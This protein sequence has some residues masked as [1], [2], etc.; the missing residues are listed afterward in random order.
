MVGL[1][2]IEKKIRLSLNVI[3]TQ[4]AVRRGPWKF[5]CVVVSTEFYAEISIHWFGND[6]ICGAESRECLT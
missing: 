3:V 4:F 5:Q 1:G 6:G 2:N